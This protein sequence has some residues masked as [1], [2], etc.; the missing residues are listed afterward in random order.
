MKKTYIIPELTMQLV[1]TEG[2][3]ALSIQ[4]GTADESDALVKGNSD[5]D[6]FDDDNTKSYNVWD[7]DW[8][9]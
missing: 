7:D 6:V 9:R 4:S 3:I 8:S 1:Q 2:L 5:W